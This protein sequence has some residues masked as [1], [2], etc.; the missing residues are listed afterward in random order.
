MSQ[1]HEKQCVASAFSLVIE[2][3]FLTLR[4]VF[5]FHA[6]PPMRVLHLK[7]EDLF[8]VSTD[9][10]ALIFYS[11][12]AQLANGKWIYLQKQKFLGKCTVV[13]AVVNAREKMWKSFLAL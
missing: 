13:I 3:Q 7:R 1:T 9:H 10:S 6:D 2:Q 12:R 8:N 11:P 5:A 4:E